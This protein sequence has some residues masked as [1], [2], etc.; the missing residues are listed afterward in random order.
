MPPESWIEH[1]RA[2][3]RE[4]L[5]WIRPEGDGFVALDALGREATGPVDWLAAEE[6]LEERGL[7]W[8]ADIW[9]LE[10]PDGTGER[11]RIVEVTPERVV[12]KGDDFGA[13]DVLTETYVLPFPAP[14][15]LRRFDGDASMLASGLSGG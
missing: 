12:V 15:T 8:L 10:L 14:A 3:D 7:H 11:V 2:G 1:R 6:A 13:I 5:G 4:R 9:L